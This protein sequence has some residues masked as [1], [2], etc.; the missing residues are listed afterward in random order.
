MVSGILAG[1]SSAWGSL[2]SWVSDKISGLVDTALA[3]IKAGSPAKEFMPVGEFSVQGIMEG[4]SSMWPDLINL[5]NGLGDDL[6]SQAQD[7]AKQVQ[8]AIGDAFGATAS[9]DRQKAATVKAVGGIA[10]GAQSGIEAMLNDAEQAAAAIN[11]PQ[12]AAAFFKLRSSQIIELGKLQ[13]QINASTD[14]AQRDRLL[15]QQDLINAAQGAE[16]NAFNAKAAGQTSTTQDLTAQIQKLLANNAIPGVL[17]NPVV[18]QLTGFLQQLIAPPSMTAPS[19][20]SASTTYNHVTNLAM[21]IYTN[22]SPDV[23]QS[24]MAIAGAALF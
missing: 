18:A 17:D 12:Q 7:I 1:L 15:A 8:G 21:P 4:F 20:S 3:A 14:R 23:L 5:V 2:T 11:D 22:Q 6:V 9:I 24:S 10:A 16:V 13:D 19:S